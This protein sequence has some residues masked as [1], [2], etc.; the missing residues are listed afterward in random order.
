MAYTF[1][2][3]AGRREGGAALPA[4]SPP[5][6]LPCPLPFARPLL[7]LPLLRVVRGSPC[8][9]GRLPSCLPSALPSSLPARLPPPPEGEVLHKYKKEGGRGEKLRL[10]PLPLSPFLL[11]FLLLVPFLPM[12][13][14]AELLA[15]LV[16]LAASLLSSLLLLAGKG[17]GSGKGA[18]S[19]EE[20]D[21]LIII[22]PY[23]CRLISSHLHAHCHHGCT[24]TLILPR[25]MTPIITNRGLHHPIL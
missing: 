18:S 4:P 7:Y 16:A 19:H 20:H 2:F 1:T 17:T 23:E 6:A 21:G 5:L 22:Y 24:R 9:V 11:P 8:S 3:E 12:P 25:T 13:S 15:A 14:S 10:R